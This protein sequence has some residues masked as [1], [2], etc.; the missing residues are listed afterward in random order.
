M[1]AFNNGIVCDVKKCKH[2]YLGTN[3][4]LK[5]V[6]VTNDCDSCTCC[7]SYEADCCGNR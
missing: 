6:K 7:G 4:T 3:C 5:T 1:D 2:N